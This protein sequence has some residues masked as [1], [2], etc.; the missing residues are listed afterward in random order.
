VTADGLEPIAQAMVENSTSSIVEP[1][2]LLSVGCVV[3]TITSFLKQTTRQTKTV[4][5]GRH[6]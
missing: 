5:L 3:Q 1:W 2:L 4:L 6:T